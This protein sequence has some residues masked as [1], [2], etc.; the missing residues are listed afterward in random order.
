MT[1]MSMHTNVCVIHSQTIC[2]LKRNCFF[3]HSRFKTYLN[4]VS[5]I[6]SLYCQ[7]QLFRHTWL[8]MRMNMMKI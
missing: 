8:Q 5:S 2:K 6:N 7:S 1:S 4:L 3:L